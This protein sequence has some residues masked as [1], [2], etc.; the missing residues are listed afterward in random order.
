ML[1]HLVSRKASGWVC[2]VSDLGLSKRLVFPPSTY[3]TCCFD[4]LLWL[5]S[6]HERTA[7]LQTENEDSYHPIPRSNPGPR[8]TASR[9][10]ELQA[11]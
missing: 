10:L 6:E 9:V 2:R 5:L 11:A 4:H 7:G 8:L 3:S 1:L